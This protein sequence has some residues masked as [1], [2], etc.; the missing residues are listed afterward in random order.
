MRWKNRSFKVTC[1]IDRV[2]GLIN[3]GVIYKISAC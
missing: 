1:E 2:Y 3:E